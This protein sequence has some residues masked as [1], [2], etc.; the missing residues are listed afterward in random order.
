MHYIYYYIRSAVRV[1]NIYI[2]KKNF[3][4]VL[5]KSNILNFDYKYFFKIEFENI[6]MI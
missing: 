6:K 3:K 4:F 1:Y 2:L 5:I